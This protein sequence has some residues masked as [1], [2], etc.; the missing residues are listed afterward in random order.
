MTPGKERILRGESGIPSSHTLQLCTLKWESD[1]VVSKSGTAS[2][3][4]YKRAQRARA[5]HRGEWLEVTAS[6]LAPFQFTLMGVCL[7]ASVSGGA[8]SSYFWALSTD[9]VGLANATEEM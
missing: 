1:E 5:G 4:V 8:T 3:E 9:T 6:A 7:E 2:S